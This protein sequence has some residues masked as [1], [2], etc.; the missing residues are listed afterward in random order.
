MSFCIKCG[1]QNTDTA[2]YCIGCGGS[3]AATLVP[4]FQKKNNIRWIITGII[5]LAVLL[6]GS[7]FLFFNKGKK[8]DTASSAI[9]NETAA[10][11]KE[12]MNQWNAGLN[13]ANATVVSALYAERVVYYRQQMS[14]GNATVLLS[15]FFQKNPSFYQQI[16]GE[17]TFEKISDN[18][19]VCNFQKKTT[20]N[21][22]TTDYPSYL[23]FAEEAGNWKILEEGDKITDYN[24]NKSK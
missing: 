19:V 12:L 15:N 21:G 24:L 9:K 6:A 1:K 22:K 18:L 3:L 13:S 17:I 16:T 8:N 2:K 10:K 23:K 20:L 7:Y 14:K 5:I 11:L 4:L